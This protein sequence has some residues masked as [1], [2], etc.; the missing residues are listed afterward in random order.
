MS[1]RVTENPFTGATTPISSYD[2]TKTNLGT[3]MLQNSGTGVADD[4]V[5]PMPVTIAR[6]L[7]ESTPIAMMFPSV[8]NFSTAIDWVFLVENAANAAK[9]IFLYEYNKLTSIY[10]WKGFITA[11]LPSATNVTH[12]FKALRYLH[13]TGTVGVGAPTSVYSTGTAALAVSGVV[14]GTSTT[15]A[16]THVGMMIGFGSTTPSSI[17]LWYPIVTFTNTTS[18][19]VSGASSAIAATS[20]VIAS[21]T[22]TG[23]STQFT[24]ELIAA[25][26]NATAVAGGL[27]ARIGFGSTD[28]TQITQWYQIGFI[29]SNTSLNIT[30]SPGV[31]ATGKSYVIEELRF[32]FAMSNTT[33]TNGGLMLLKG[34]GYTDFTTAGNTFPSIAS[35]VDNQRGVYWLDDAGAGAVTNTA[36]SGIAV[37][38]EVSKTSHTAYVLDGAGT[39]SVKIYAYNLRANN[40]VAAGKM[41][42]AGANIVI[43]GSFTVMGILPA[44]ATVAANNF[45]LATL[46]HGPGS[47][48]KYLYFVTTDYAVAGTVT[49][50]AA[51]TTVTGASTAFTAAMVGLRI[52]FGSTNRALITNWYTIATFSSGTSI[53]VNVAPGA[54]AAGS[55]YVIDAGRLYC[56]AVSG[57]S[58]ASTT[59]ITASNARQEVPPG[60]IV[61]YPATGAMLNVLYISAIDRLLITTASGA[62]YRQ[63]VTQYPA[64][65][66]T[67]FDHIFGIDDKQ[68]DQSLADRALGIHFNTASQVLSADDSDT[69]VV[70]I[71]K[72]GTTAALCQMY[73]LPLGAHWTYASSTNQRVITPSMNTTGCVKFDQVLVLDNEYVGGGELRIAPESF[74]VYYRTTNIASDATSSWTLVTDD[75]DLSS[76]TKADAIQFMLEFFT[77]GLTCIPSRILNVL[78]TWEDGS[79]DAHYQL[80]SSLSDIN[81]KTFSWRFSQPFDDT[82]P[83]LKVS[84]FNAATGS[85]LFTDTTAAHA[86]GAWS[87]STDGGGNW[88]SY[89]SIDKGNETTYIRYTPTSITD[90]I[91]VQAVLTQN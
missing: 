47:G 43:T 18:I 12:G 54:F 13:T 73:A 67:P 36:S 50:S 74:R 76:V 59:F 7:E 25:G 24:S 3:L 6:P 33:T 15:F 80:S 11:T 68:Q 66:G 35:A 17:N 2:S 49:I 78:V 57:I 31:I 29:T 90:S 37:D 91:S 19:T 52:G 69:G 45:I 22:V 64:T 32:A 63:Y 38:A 65:D 84:F 5:G 1:L 28:P 72:S 26:T 27:G 10:N 53:T 40:T 87:K 8:I 14:T 89:D 70:H 9:R 77:I 39:S 34:V 21:C 88:G 58:S 30:T 60:G 75:G 56:A 61:T 83:D 85:L 51:S 55:A 20:F 71:C 86:S 82:V 41:Q 62:S 4:Y 23:S 48:S 79:T 44:V 16:V 42:L 46:S 81:A